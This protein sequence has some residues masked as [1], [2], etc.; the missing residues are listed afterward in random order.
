MSVEDTSKLSVLKHR[1]F[2]QF[3][4]SRVMG[5]LANQMQTIAVSWQVYELTGSPFDLGLVGLA[6]FLPLVA[7]MLVAGHV[8]DRYD[9]KLVVCISQIVDGVA[10]GIL[11]LGTAGGWLTRDVI[12]AMVLGARCGGGLVRR[13]PRQRRAQSRRH[14]LQTRLPRSSALRSAASCWQSASRWFI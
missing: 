10:M 13:P 9:R 11:A 6:Q 5:S 14:H 3:W 2:A 4:L 8:A 7:L 12:L 1:P